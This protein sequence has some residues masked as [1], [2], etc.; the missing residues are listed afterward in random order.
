M[1]VLAAF[2]ERVREESMAVQI[3]GSPDGMS[4]RIKLQR[5]QRRRKLKAFT[6]V[7]PL[8]LFMLIARL[9]DRPDDVQRDP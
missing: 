3:V 4:L 9:A 8:L 6:L 1:A 7:L 2:L 5:V